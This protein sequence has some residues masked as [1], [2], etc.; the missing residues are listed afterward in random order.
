[1]INIFLPQSKCIGLFYIFFVFLFISCL[2]NNKKTESN[3]K[4]P[5]VETY[6]QVDILTEKAQIAGLEN[7]IVEKHE[8][9]DSNIVQ[10]EDLYYLLRASWFDDSIILDYAIATNELEKYML[11]YFSV[12]ELTFSTKLLDMIFTGYAA[13]KDGLIRVFSWSTASSREPF[14]FDSLIQ[15]R[16]PDGS[17]KVTLIPKMIS[18]EMYDDSNITKLSYVNYPAELQMEY[19]NVFFIKPNVYLIYGSSTEKISFV[20]IEIKESQ[21]VPYRAFKGKIRLAYDFYLPGKFHAV[22]LPAIIETRPNFGVE[23]FYIEFTYASAIDPKNNGNYDA[24][25]LN[26]DEVKMRKEQFIFN[27]TEFVG[28]YSIFD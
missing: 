7:Y 12:N 24:G 20:S 10:I 27:G 23:P 22:G 6:T 28:D 14:C 25:I 18:D 1:M 11:E 2:D 19:T 3:E 13:S 26:E 4:I 17:F 9:I 16:K 15:Y 8:D 21:V 5:I